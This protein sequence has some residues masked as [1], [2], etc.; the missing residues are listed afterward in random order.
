MRTGT[1][2]YQFQHYYQIGCTNPINKCNLCG[3]ANDID[4]VILTCPKW[5]AYRIMIYEQNKILK[6]PN[7]IS[8]VLG[9]NF[10]HG[11]LFSYLRAIKYFD[12]I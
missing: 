2:R 12:L 7:S 8:R 5:E 4:H 9:D 1:C 3:V 6:L 11:I 10:N